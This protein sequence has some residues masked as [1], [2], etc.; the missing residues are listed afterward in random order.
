V[1]EPC[2]DPI[3]RD[4]CGTHLGLR[5]HQVHDEKPCGACQ[6]G[7]RVRLLDVER[8]RPVPPVP[9]RKLWKWW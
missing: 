4:A 9:P 3:H 8:Q 7:E 1:N 5:L 6:L 2:H